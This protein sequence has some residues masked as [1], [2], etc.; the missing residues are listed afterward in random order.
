V[1]LYKK[2]IAGLTWFD[3]PKITFS[4]TKKESGRGRRAV[5]SL[6]SLYT[7]AITNRISIYYVKKIKK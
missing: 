4:R 3:V 7:K 5:T 6:R 1:Y 2:N